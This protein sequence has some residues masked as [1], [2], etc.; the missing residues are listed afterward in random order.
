MKD[1]VATI[2]Q[3]GP[4]SLEINLV[5]ITTDDH[6][7]SNAKSLKVI[8]QHPNGAKKIVLKKHPARDWI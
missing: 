7:R 5:P 8:Q 6:K 2:L 4:E 1:N 3:I